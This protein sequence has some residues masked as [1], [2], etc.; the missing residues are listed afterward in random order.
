MRLK[1][2]AQICELFPELCIGIVTASPV[3]NAHYPDELAAFVRQ[4]SDAARRRFAALDLGEDPRIASWRQA[5]EAMG[6]NP[7]KH[8]PTAEAYVSRV[9]RGKPPAR[10]SAVV[11]A[12]LASEL[13]FL[14]PVGAYDLETLAGD[15]CLCRASG[16]EQ[17]SPLGAGPVEK[18]DAGEIVYK[19]SARVLTRRW[20]YRDADPTKITLQTTRLILCTESVDC[21]FGAEYIAQSVEDIAQLL[22]QFCGAGTTAQVLC[23]AALADAEIRLPA[24]QCGTTHVFGSAV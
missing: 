5:Y 15:I 9:L 6:V 20:N 10:I 23:G 13:E 7:K 21:R 4:R 3:N 2:D 16:E 14:L 12:Y 22:R 17:F 8:T 1:V 11:D 18:V 24:A 19:D